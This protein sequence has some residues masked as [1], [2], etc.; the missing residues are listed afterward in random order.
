VTAPAVRRPGRPRDTRAEHAILT[1]TVDLL[2]ETG[3]AGVNVEAIA[4]RAGVGK[5]T[6]YR[7]WPG[8]ERLVYDALRMLALDHL[9]V[10]TGS[11]RSDLVHIYGRL[12]EHVRNSRVGRA[13]AAALAQ[14]MVDPELRML[15]REFVHERRAAA[16]AALRR[17]VG[18]G[19][20]PAHTDSD[21]VIDLLGGT[22]FYRL[23]V[24]GDPITPKRVE[25]AV[26]VVL[27]GIFTSVSGSSGGKPADS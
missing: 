21:L 14:A 22:V 12:A 19:E 5:A 26:D 18:R 27:R 20:I 7:H 11:L 23:I 8:K 10:D 16:R 17:A 13:L 25:A 24:S 15:Q 1:A 2:S 9:D 4:E 3:Y 6:I